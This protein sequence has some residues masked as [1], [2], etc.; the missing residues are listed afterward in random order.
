MK[1][2]EILRIAIIAVLAMLVVRL[3]SKKV[4]ALKPLAG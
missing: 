1:A 3:A 4:P 2:S